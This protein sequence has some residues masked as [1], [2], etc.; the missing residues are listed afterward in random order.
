M[1]LCINAAV[2]ARLQENF[3]GPRGWE[4]AEIVSKKMEK[5]EK[6]SQKAHL[7][8]FHFPYPCH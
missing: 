8:A 7:I 1:A 5:T 2:P 6:M 4:I 3:S